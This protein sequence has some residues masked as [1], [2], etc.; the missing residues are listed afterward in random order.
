RSDASLEFLGRNDF[1]VKIRGHRIELGE[2]EAR[3]AAQAQVRQAVV[4]ALP[5]ASGE[6]RLVAWFTT[7]AGMPEPETLR[8]H[9]LAE[10]PAWMVPSAY[11]HL[12]ALPLTPNGKLDR[13]AL[14]APQAGALAQADYEAPQGEDE[15]SM[16]ALWAAVLN[17]ERVGRHDDFFALG[18]HSLLA[19][20][21]MEKLRQVGLEADVKLLFEQPTLAQYVAA[22][23]KT[24]IVL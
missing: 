9:L 23:E 11:V 17:V 2:I 3:L 20:S 4:G 6:L 18:G 5:D 16:A 13:K 14:P 24:E 21:L 10:L 7:E 12:A 1:Q 22:L 15:C 8:A 19:V